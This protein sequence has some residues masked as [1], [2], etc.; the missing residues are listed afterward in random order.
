MTDNV[1]HLGD[2]SPAHWDMRAMLR[3][4]SIVI[5]QGEIPETARGIIIFLNDENDDYQVSFM[6]CDIRSSELVALLEFAKQYYLDD[7]MS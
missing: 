6:R 1:I 2:H 7:L 4:A 5:E 3:Q